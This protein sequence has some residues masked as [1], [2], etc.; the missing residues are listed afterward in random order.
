MQKSKTKLPEDRVPELLQA[1]KKK[2]QS[3][4]LL[5]KHLLIYPPKFSTGR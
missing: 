4:R 3:S 1:P 5:S 2:A